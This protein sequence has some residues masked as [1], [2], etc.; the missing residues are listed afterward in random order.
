MFL[1][2]SAEAQVSR[3][4]QARQFII[5]N[6]RFSIVNLEFGLEN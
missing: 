3:Q 6:L 2:S 5:F 4:E 1:C